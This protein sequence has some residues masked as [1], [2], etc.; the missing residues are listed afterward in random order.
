[1]VA[2]SAHHDPQRGRRLPVVV[3]LARPG[4]HRCDVRRAGGRSRRRAAPGRT[5]RPRKERAVTEHE[6][7]GYQ[8]TARLLRDG[9]ADLDV[10]VTLRGMFQP[11]DGRYH[12]Y[13]RVS[14][15]PRVDDL[16]AAG[17]PVVLRTPHGDAPARLS[18]RDPWGRFRIAGTG[19]PPFPV[20]DPASEPVPSD[21]G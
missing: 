14:S 15:D 7:E 10:E 19:R 4:R 3:R 9:E 1:M 11:I 6:D 17:P 21:I 5:T 18:D 12:W 2:D 20:P 16:A 8:G 13:G